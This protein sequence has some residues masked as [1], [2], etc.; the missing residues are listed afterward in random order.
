MEN[1]SNHLLTLVTFVYFA[2]SLFY[3]GLEIFKRINLGIVASWLTV[4]A[5]SMLS[6]AF[7]LRW[8]ANHQ[9]GMGHAPLS[10][11]FESLILF[12]WLLNLFYLWL[13]RRLAWRRVGTIV[14]PLLFF[15]LLYAGWI[16]PTIKP[17]LPALQSNWLI[18]HVL[19]CFLG[20]AFFAISFALALL[21]L[22]DREKNPQTAKQTL[23]DLIYQTAVLGFVMLSAGI[24]TGAVWAEAAWGSYWSWDPKEIWSLITWLVYATML[25]SRYLR[26][27]SGQ[28]LAWLAILGFSCVIFTYL[29]VNFLLGG[30]HAY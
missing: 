15:I 16:D 23:T 21:Y 10:N 7:I 18:T 5:L 3:L 19:T 22:L 6:A 17:L 8:L 4:T 11:L 30:Q 20:Y 27:G 1:I 26:G 9:L 14:L 13:E 12:A 28:R 24:A 2:A 29:G 25:H